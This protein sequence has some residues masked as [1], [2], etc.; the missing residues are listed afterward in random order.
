VNRQFGSIG[1][2]LDELSL[3]LRVE[4]AD[5]CAAVGTESARAVHYAKRLLHACG[6][7]EAVRVSVEQ[8]IPAHVGLGSGTQLALATGVAV[9]ELFGLRLSVRDVA[10]IL[11]RG[12][13]S[14]VGI[15]AF[16]RGGFLVDGGRGSGGAAPPVVSRIAFPGR[17]RVILIFDDRFEGL[18]DAEEVAG[19]A[20]LPPFPESES[21]RLCQRVL[22]GV[23]PGLAEGDLEQFGTA[24]SDIQRTV[25]DYFAPVQGGR[26]TSRV[27]ADALS[28]LEG[29]GVTCV[30]QSSWG[31]TGFAIVESE[32]RAQALVAAGRSRAGAA[33]APRFMICRGRNRGAGIER[34]AAQDRE[35]NG[36]NGRRDARYADAERPAAH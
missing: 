7:R 28:W 27:V 18:H 11:D 12:R 3:R 5:A 21:A 26:F 29:E 25:G 22:M 30:G 1:L 31:P 10:R 13:R 20:R 35:H 15:G 19:F 16:E 32:R 9:S 33:S 23:L 4:H 14:G 2:A 24:V 6:L 17:W 36:R 34:D 8:A